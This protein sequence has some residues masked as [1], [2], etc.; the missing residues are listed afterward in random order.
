MQLATT[1]H[2]TP[3][4]IRD[5]DARITHA[6][7]GDA[8]VDAMVR[9]ARAAMDWILGRTDIAPVTQ[10]P[11]S[12]ETSIQHEAIFAASVSEGFIPGDADHGP[13]Y[14]R[15]AE[16]LLYWAILGEPLPWWLRIARP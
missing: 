3:D 10:L 6:P 14:G 13:D 5:A 9:G 1:I 16:C 2:R 15:G 4:E 8:V 11:L 7:A 12:V